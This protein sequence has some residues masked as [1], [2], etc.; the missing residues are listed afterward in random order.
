MGPEL[1][2]AIQQVG[3]GRGG[4]DVEYDLV[5]VQGR[6]NG[7]AYALLLAPYTQVPC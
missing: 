4:P 3:S 6:F 7:G 1:G 5:T 2:N